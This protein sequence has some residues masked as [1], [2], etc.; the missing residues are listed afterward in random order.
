MRLNRKGGPER[1]IDEVEKLAPAGFE[2]VDRVL[3]HAE[4]EA[5]VKGYASTAGFTQSQVNK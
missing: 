1:V 2:S 4:R 5:I 3:S